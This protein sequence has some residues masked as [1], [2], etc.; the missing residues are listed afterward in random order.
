MY[1]YILFFFPLSD[2]FSPPFLKS[3]W[4]R[5]S[6]PPGC[7]GSPPGTADSGSATPPPP[8]PQHEWV[9]HSRGLGT[10]ALPSFSPG[11][12][13]LLTSSR[14]RVSRQW[15]MGDSVLNG[16]GWGGF[17]PPLP[18]SSPTREVDT[19]GCGAAWTHQDAFSVENPLPP[20]S[21]PQGLVLRVSSGF[22]GKTPTLRG[23]GQI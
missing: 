15:W 1:I 4:R 13:A 5:G 22:A 16:V 3:R 2:Q 11:N 8:P 20:P 6:V 14:G 7:A 23:G 21:P 9:S 10:A 19:H 17:L 18:T 12:K